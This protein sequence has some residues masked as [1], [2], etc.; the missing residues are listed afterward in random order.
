MIV[1]KIFNNAKVKKYLLFSGIKKIQHSSPTFEIKILFVL[2]I[3]KVL[4]LFPKKFV[5]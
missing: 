1:D 4:S 2:D 3:K 5:L